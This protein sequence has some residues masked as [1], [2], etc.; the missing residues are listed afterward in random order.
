MAKINDRIIEEIDKIKFSK[1]EETKKFHNS[2]DILS[3]ILDSLYYF[4]YDLY[5]N[6]VRGI[7]IKNLLKHK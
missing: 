1:L 2:Y 3:K 7:I 5:E 4:D 6:I